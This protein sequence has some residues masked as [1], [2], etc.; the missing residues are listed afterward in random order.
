MTNSRIT[1]PEVME[2]RF[3]VRVGC[4]GVRKGSGGRGRHRGGCGVVREL[5]FE[6]AMD[7]SVLSNRRH[8]P[9]YG[10][11]GG[12]PGALGKHWVQRAKG[13]GEGGEGG[14]GEVVAM[15]SCDTVRVEPGDSFWM[16]TPGGGG[17]GEEEGA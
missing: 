16:L 5:I 15:D 11:A 7:L 12:Q 9:P 6:E 14:G 2:L 8:V 17:Y 10:L 1:D 3:P 13:G 4:F